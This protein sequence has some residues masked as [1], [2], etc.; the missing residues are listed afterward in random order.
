MATIKMFNGDIPPTLKKGEWA[1]NGIFAYLGIGSRKYIVF[2]G[3]EVNFEE[4][5]DQLREN[6]LS[7]VDYTDLSNTPTT[8]TAEQIAAI[9]T[10][11]KKQ[12]FDESA[13]TKLDQV[14]EKATK[15]ADWNTNVANKPTTITTVQAQAIEANTEKVSYPKSDKDKLAKIEAEATKGADWNTNVANKPATITPEQA[16]AIETNTQKQGLSEE[17]Q[18]ALAA[19]QTLTQTV[20]EL[21]QSI[22]EL[23]QRIDGLGE[24]TN[25]DILG[26]QVKKIEFKKDYMVFKFHD[27]EEQKIY[28]KYEEDDD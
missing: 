21:E 23:T 15:G 26:E 20:A 28:Y 22:D 18:Q 25:T 7:V 2:A 1:S 24:G 17:D 5:I 8:I 10:N 19:A 9:E 12:S 14:E 4:I 16:E 13:K 27:D 3:G 6:Y 11:S